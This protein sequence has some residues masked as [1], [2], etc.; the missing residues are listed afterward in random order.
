MKYLFL[1]GLVLTLAMC[2]EDRTQSADNEIEYS[3][4]LHD[5]AMKLLDEMHHHNDSLINVYFPL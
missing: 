4:K 5:S 3:H 1:I 2:S